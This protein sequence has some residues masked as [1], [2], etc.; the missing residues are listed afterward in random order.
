VW[1]DSKGLLLKSEEGRRCALGA[2]GLM[3]MAHGGAVVLKRLFWIN[4]DELKTEELT[5]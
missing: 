3:S 4:R 2:V 5:V 1:S